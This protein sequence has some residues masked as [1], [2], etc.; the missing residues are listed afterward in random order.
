MSTNIAQILQREDKPGEPSK[1]EQIRDAWPDLT[2]EQR[3]EVCR[4]C[5]SYFPQ[6]EETFECLSGHGP[7]Y[8]K[9][10]PSYCEAVF[11]LCD[12]WT[13]TPKQVYLTRELERLCKLAAG[14]YNEEDED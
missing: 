3:K 9:A 2:E 11:R 13:Y 10:C 7:R 5:V 12:G 8:A 6:D 14:E 1:R 4:T